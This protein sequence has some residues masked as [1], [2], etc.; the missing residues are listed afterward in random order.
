MSHCLHF[1]VCGG[2]AFTDGGGPDKAAMVPG[3]VG[4][5][6]IPVRRRRVDWG[7]VRQGPAVLLGLH[8]ARSK[9]V[10]DVRECAVLLPGIVALAAPVREVLRRMEGFR[11]EGSVVVNWLDGG[12]DVLV[13]V[14]GKVSA[15][16]RAKLVVFSRE[17]GVVRVSVAEGEGEPEAVA[18]LAPPVITMS[19]IA[20]EPAAGAFLQASREGEEAIVAAVVAGLPRMKAKDRIVELYAGVGTISFALRAY[21]RVEAYEGN[22][23]AVAAHEAAIRRHNLA[24]VMR[25]TQRDLARRPLKTEEMAGAAVVVLDPPYAGAGAQMKNVAASGV[26]RVIYVSCNPVALAS[27]AEWLRKA[28]YEVV[29]AVA[30]DQFPYS[31]NVESVVVFT[32]V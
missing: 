8:Q 16:D 30:I 27:D 29:S 18:I 21:A 4:V 13:R 3:A 2:C 11:R 25:V 32:K 7:A 15:P 20:V 22:G 19:G 28:G 1:G 12:A 23:A 10:V 5:V 9:N 26:K 31:E 17:H 14:D 24:G 6:E